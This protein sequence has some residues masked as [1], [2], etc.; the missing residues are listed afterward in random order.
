MRGAK[1]ASTDASDPIGSFFAQLSARGHEPLLAHS[2]G[3]LRFDLRDGTNVERWHVTVTKGDVEVS[4]D[5]REA[6]VTFAVDKAVFAA[7]TEGRVNAM[8]AT[9][10]GVV[11]P[12]GDLAL[13]M[14]F[15]RVFPGHPDAVGPST[16]RREIEVTP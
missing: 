6:D 9:L 8:A 3:T 10:R 2:T 14:A 15:Q 12:S 16:P 1:A 11:T 7:M 13:A 5:D 4:R